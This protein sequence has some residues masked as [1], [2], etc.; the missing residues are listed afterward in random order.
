MEKVNMSRFLTFVALLALPLTFATPAAAA[1]PPTA[2]V[3]IESDCS[4]WS[5]AINY[6]DFS[7]GDVFVA[8]YLIPGMPGSDGFWNLGEWVGSGHEIAVVGIG[9]AAYVKVMVDINPFGPIDPPAFTV[10]IGN[11]VGNNTIDDQPTVTEAFF[12]MSGCAPAQSS[13]VLLAPSVE[14]VPNCTPAPT[15]TPKPTPTPT[16]TARITPTPRVTPTPTPQVTPTPTPSPSP[17]PTATPTVGPTS[18]ATATAEATPAPTPTRFAAATPPPT[19]TEPPSGTP[20]PP[21][22]LIGFALLG[23]LFLMHQWL[24]RRQ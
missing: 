22:V 16:P 4:G 19:A 14:A 7:Y 13:V 21:I 9:P 1:S 2:T 11:I 6:A 5:V 18:T 23:I 20:P 8:G 15:K 17:T 24:P 10:P 3:T 12:D